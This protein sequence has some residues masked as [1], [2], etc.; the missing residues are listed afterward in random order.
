[1]ILLLFEKGRSRK[2]RRK[3]N[4]IARSHDKT[5]IYKRI[6]CVLS[7]ENIFVKKGRE[8]KEKAAEETF[9]NNV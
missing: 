2:E 6:L 3:K 7:M 5:Y 9:A 4:T 8:M 1:M